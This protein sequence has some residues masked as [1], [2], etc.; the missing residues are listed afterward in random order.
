MGEKYLRVM[1]QA[2]W[3]AADFRSADQQQVLANHPASRTP[4]SGLTRGDEYCK[5][6]GKGGTT[7]RLD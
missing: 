5:G 1:M 3:L 4:K 7:K 6:R 2:S